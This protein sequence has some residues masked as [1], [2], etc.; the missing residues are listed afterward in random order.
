VDA[1]DGCACSM[2]ALVA[3]LASEFLEASLDQFSN[4]PSLVDSPPEGLPRLQ[5]NMVPWRFMLAACGTCLDASL[6]G[7]RPLRVNMPSFHIFGAHDSIRD[8]SLRLSQCFQ[9]A[10]C[11]E[12]MYAAHA[13]P[14]P[15]LTDASLTSALSKFFDRMHAAC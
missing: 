11:Q 8:R 3:A 9:D 5:N 13:V 6:Q 4:A 7:A 15:C 2:G 1:S 12:L 10:V 14:N